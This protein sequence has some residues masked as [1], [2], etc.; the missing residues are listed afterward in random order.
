MYTLNKWHHKLPTLVVAALLSACGGGG[1]GGG[2]TTTPP[3]I[4]PPTTPPTT[5][6][7]V[8]PTGLPG[9]TGDTAI[10]GFNWFN[11]RRAD[12]GLTMLTCN[13]LLNKAAVGHSNYLRLNNTVS[14]DQVGGNPGFTGASLADR[15]AAAGYSLGTSYA[16]G[17]VISAASDRAGFYHA[18]ELIAAIYHRFVIFEPMFREMG[19]GASTASGGYT[20]FTA[21]LATRN[22]FGAGLGKGNIVTYP[23]NT[24]TAVPTTFDSDTESPDPVPNLNRVGYPISVH[25]D[26]TGNVTVTSF[27]VRPRGGAQLNTRLLTSGTDQHTPVH[28][29]AIVPLSTLTSNTIYDVAFTG[30][31]DSVAVTKNWSFTTK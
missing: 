27:T 19:T 18:E 14:H 6:C 12:I 7:V 22:G 26:I 28:A 8:S 2:S 10:D 16:Y 9:A 13:E 1:G 15:L 25:S 24:Q 5:S 30:T 21:D 17:E 4:N 29:A 3:V 20:Y 23:K 31:V 11:Y